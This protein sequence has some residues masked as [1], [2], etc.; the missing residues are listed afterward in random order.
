MVDA[1]AFEEKKATA[2]ETVPTSGRLLESAL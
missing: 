1:V 2:T